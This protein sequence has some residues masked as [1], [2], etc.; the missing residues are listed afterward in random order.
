M[1]EVV[2]IVRDMISCND[3]QLCSL[4]NVFTAVNSGDSDS[5]R[6]A[7]QLTYLDFNDHAVD[8]GGET[9]IIQL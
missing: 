9:E 6:N 8:Y 3:L 4:S 1:L 5:D 2:G 7:L